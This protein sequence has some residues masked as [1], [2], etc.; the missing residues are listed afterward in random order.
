MFYFC[1]CSHVKLPAVTK[2]VN[3]VATKSQSEDSDLKIVEEETVERK[4]VVCKRT[5]QKGSRGRG[6]KTQPKKTVTKTKDEEVKPNTKQISI[7][8]VSRMIKRLSQ[9]ELSPQKEIGDDVEI[10]EET[11]EKTVEEHVQE[12]ETKPKMHKQTAR[13]GV[14]LHPAK[15]NL[16]R[17]TLREMNRVENIEEPQ[18]SRSI[19]LK[20]DYEV[21][22]SQSSY[23]E[24]LKDNNLAGASS[25]KE[26][27]DSNFVIEINTTN[28]EIRKKRRSVS[29][30]NSLKHSQFNE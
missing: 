23:E 3:R 13:R 10:K 24:W 9:E 21:D 17:K 11:E 1:I 6:C 4:S 22:L 18:D 12:T 30:C 2:A 15:R 20:N 16:Y 25:D 26:N 29:R 14:C 19:V 5:G 8:D 28:G 7:K 27:P